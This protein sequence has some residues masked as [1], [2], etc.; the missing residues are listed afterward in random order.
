MKAIAMIKKYTAIDLNH[1]RRAALSGIAG[2]VIAGV[3]SR[4]SMRLVAVFGGLETSF[5]VGG[6]LAILLVGAFFGIPFA[7][8]FSGVG[9]FLPFPERWKGLAYGVILG[10]LFVVLPFLLIEDGELELVDPRVGIL[11]FFPLPVTFG[12]VQTLIHPRLKGRYD[13]Q[14]AGRI[15]LP[16]LVLLGLGLIFTISSTA[17]LVSRFPLIPDTVHGAFQVLGLSAQK[18]VNLANVVTVSFIVLYTGLVV[19]I[20]WKGAQHWM[21]RF[22]ALTL[23]AFGGTFMTR[24]LLPGEAM[25][26]LPLVRWLPIFLR[27]FGLGSLVI[28]FYIFP[29]GRFDPGW[30]RWLAVIW[31][32]WLLVWF[33]GLLSG[34]PLSPNRWDSSALVFVIVG[35]LGSATL[36]QI[37]RYRKSEPDEK[38]PIRSVIFALIVILIVFIFLG[39][40]MA[41]DPGLRVVPFA[42]SR[43]SFLF[44]FSPYLLPW[45]VIPA[46][47]LYAILRRGLWQ[48][49]SSH[50]FPSTGYIP[51]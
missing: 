5:S 2:G 49:Q 24:G 51:S 34:T 45:L 38:M 12:L 14:T 1:F 17:K 18:L 4:F 6:T 43:L 8:I 20:I 33:A 42:D 50:P 48:Q 39:L 36:A 29:N 28:L 11:L 15:S 40:G 23:L 27:T 35:G 44:S 7:L 10:V 41:V 21:S 30:T 3:V 32:G 47:L 22:A 31:S 9:R 13:D 19:A 16:G 46:A 26:A 37:S 25:N